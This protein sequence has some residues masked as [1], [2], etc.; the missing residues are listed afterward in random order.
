MKNANYF[1]LIISPISSEKSNRLL[2]ENVYVFKVASHANKYQVKDAVEAVFNTKVDSVRISNVKEKIKYFRGRE[3]SRKAW[4]K[5][6]VTLS[7][8]QSIEG[9]LN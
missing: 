8:G 6:Y 1:N 4:K 9:S 3:G 7:E 2:G 5:A